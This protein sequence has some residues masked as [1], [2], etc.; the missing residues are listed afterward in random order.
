[1]KKIVVALLL[2]LIG[3]I[4][5]A[6]V[7]N[8]QDNYQLIYN[9]VDSD[10]N[11]VSS[12]TVTLKIKKISNDYWY[13]FNDDT[14][15]TSGWTNKTTNLSEDGTDDYYYY[16]FNPPASESSADQYMMLIDNVSA[17]YGDHQAL[18]VTYQDIGNS[19]FDAS[20]NDVYVSSFT[21]AGQ[22]D[23]TEVLDNQG[24]SST[25][26]GYI[27]K[28]NFTGSISTGD[29]WSTELPGAYTGLQAGNILDLIKQYTNG[30]KDS[31]VYNGIEFLIRRNR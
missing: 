9:I 3:N 22:A 30:I 28:L 10:G 1:M 12:E 29:M 27:D 31:G 13:D 23:I 17:T 6:N 8:I 14:F 18:T 4:C 21:S 20:S 7:R 26:A 25:R 15:K 24:Y 2:L 19:D 16:T 5:Y 11:P